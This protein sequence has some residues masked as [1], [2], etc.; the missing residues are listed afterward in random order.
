MLNHSGT[1]KSKR[2]GTNDFVLLKE[3][4]K[5]ITEDESIA[6]EINLYFSVICIHIRTK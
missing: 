5:D 1:I 3:D 6:Q 2:K 4:G